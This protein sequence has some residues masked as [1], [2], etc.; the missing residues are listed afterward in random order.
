[1]GDQKMKRKG[2][3]YF[4]IMR[5][6]L[7]FIGMTL[8][9]LLLS[10]GA[11]YFGSEKLADQ[12]LNNVNDTT[13]TYQEPVPV[14]GGPGSMLVHSKFDAD[15]GTYSVMD[16]KILD[17]DGKVLYQNSDK[18]ISEF[19]NEITQD[20]D[21]SVSR[22]YWLYNQGMH[23]LMV[24]IVVGFL[25]GEVLSMLFFVFRMNQKVSKPLR[26]LDDAMEEMQSEDLDKVSP[27]QYQGPQELRSICQSYNR[28]LN[29]LKTSTL[30]RKQLEKGRQR[31]IAGISH[32]LKTPIT[33]IQG[34]SR[35]IVDGTIPEER[36]K[37]YAD[38]IYRK[39]VLLTDLINTFHEYSRLE[40]P[41][42][43]FHKEWGD[44]VEYLREY[45]A[46]KYEE[47]SLSHYGLE[48]NLPEERVDYYFDKVEFRRIFE[49]L[50]NNTVRYNPEGT[51]IYVSLTVSHV[52]HWIVM[53]VADDG[54]GI[55]EEL[56]QNI[57]DAFVT[58]DAS[59]QSGKGSGL[60]LA[61]VRRVVEGHGG[62]ITL[63]PKGA[64]GHSTTYRIILPR[65]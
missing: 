18:S 7:G 59:R 30:E 20:A 22:Q 39:S 12:Y 21:Q 11:Y 45:L 41:D 1:M 48:V 37:R 64:V 16:L 40:H 26:L 60:G 36:W 47:L 53:D 15:Q 44:L 38:T 63:L 10:G 55:P 34:Y 61:I 65:S 14:T 19:R 29:A 52:N 2:S 33:V 4:L 57:F 51:N 56:R 17:A 28:M 24:G 9:L 27:I 13:Y 32:D 42:F 31:L 50:I 8:I 43:S 23:R 35:A 49:N 46:A 6:Y 54:I 62:T 3:L 25:L 58:G 5:G